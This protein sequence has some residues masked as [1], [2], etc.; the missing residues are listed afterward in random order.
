MPAPYPNHH[1]FAEIVGDGVMTVADLAAAIRKHMA[2][3]EGVPDSLPREVVGPRLEVHKYSSQHLLA[4]GTCFACS[5]PVLYN[6]AIPFVRHDP[7]VEG[8]PD[9]W[10]AV[11]G[12]GGRQ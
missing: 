4:R 3:C 10:P 5:R 1:C 8:C 12:K 6:L 9:P 2:V 7:E 11:P